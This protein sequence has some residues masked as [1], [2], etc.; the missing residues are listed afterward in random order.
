MFSPVVS[1][2][3][4][5]ILLWFLT[6]QTWI[7]SSGWKQI[8]LQELQLWVCFRCGRDT[9]KEEPYASDVLCVLKEFP[10]AYSS[11]VWEG[12]QSMSH[13]FKSFTLLVTVAKLKN[14]RSKEIKLCSMHFSQ[15]LRTET[16]WWSLKEEVPGT[17]WFVSSLWA[18][19]TSG[20]V[21][22]LS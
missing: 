15:E 8:L 2:G 9:R 19:S 12:N 6:E 1:L 7:S 16:S 18:E 3:Q 10:T 17:W 14:C 5:G 22:L 11:A 4:G 13:K 21:Q 20:F